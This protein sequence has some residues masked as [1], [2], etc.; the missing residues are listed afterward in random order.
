MKRNLIVF[1]LLFSV[2][3]V[4][5]TPSNDLLLTFKEYL[6]YVKRF[7]PI[8][9]QAELTVSV[10]EANLLRSRGAFDPKINVDYNRKEFK[11]TEYFDQLNTTFKIPTWYG[12]ELKANFEQNSGD[13]LN[14]EGFLP[15][16]GLYSAGI[17]ASL[18]RGLLINERMA[19]LKTAKFF[20]EQTKA[21]RDILVNQILFDAAIAY[22]NWLRAYQETEIYN[23]FL[24]NAQI[25]FKGIRQSA[26]AG[27]IAAIDTIEAKIAV[28]NRKLSLEQANLELF[29][30]RLEVSNFLWINDVPV[31]L[32]QEVIPDTNPVLDIDSSFETMGLTL[33]QFTL[34]NH[35]KLRSLNFKIEA[36]DIDRRLKA[37]KLLPRLDANY[38]FLTET[39][40]ISRS[41]NTFNYKGGI[42]FELPLFLRK[43]RGDLRLAKF[44]VQDAQFD[45]KNEELTIQNKVIAIFNA[46]E[47]FNRQNELI[48]TIVQ[49]NRVLLN[50]EERKFSFGES[51]LFLINTRELNLI[52][53]E[54]KSI[55]VQNK[56]FETKAKLFNSLATNPANL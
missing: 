48:S 26:L 22:F 3:S 46:L 5:Q 39:P 9:R 25:R 4:A 44:K 51:S 50:A 56:Y 12:I 52:N 38:N 43:E 1:L 30:K 47:S 41:L 49:D 37:N 16:D 7:H 14:P 18:L 31:E 27:D 23:N 13:F 19:D 40:D 45:F 35:P 54:L 42:N 53:A 32:Q 28:E 24:E 36:L 34:E 20:R 15:D 10:G 2:F 33:D 21:D 11:D 55:E 8:A 6:G 17:S 29:K